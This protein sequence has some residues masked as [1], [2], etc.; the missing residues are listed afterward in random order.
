[1]ALPAASAPAFADEPALPQEAASDVE[2]HALSSE[3]ASGCEGSDA[4]CEAAAGDAVAPHVGVA[5][6]EAD[7]AAMELEEALG[8][9]ESDPYVPLSDDFASA[10]AASLPQALKEVSEIDAQ[11]AALGDAA[12]VAEKIAA[13]TLPEQ[14][15]ILFLQRSL[16]EDAGYGKLAEF[17]GKSQD[18][19]AFLQWLLSDYETLA[20]YVT[21][22]RPGGNY[23]EQN[24]QMAK[25]S[26]E[27][28]IQQFMDI[29]RAN[30][31]DLK[32]SVPEADRLVYK[33]MM[34]SAA[35][36]MHSN[37]RLWVGN[38]NAYADP[39]DRYFII[40]TF[41][42][43]AQ[44]YHFNKELFDRLPVE[45]MRWVFENRISNEEMP[46]LANY[47]ISKYPD[48]EGARMNAYNYVEYNLSFGGYGDK[49]FFD[50]HYLYTEGVSKEP[51]D[52]G[53]P[54]EGGYAKKYRFSYE[55]E[56]FPNADESD[57][58]YYK[59]YSNPRGEE[60]RLWMPFEKGGVCGAL[61]KTY[62]NLSGIAGIPAA[63]AGQPKHA[64]CLTYSLVEDK[65]A[66][67]D[68]TKK[69]FY[70]LVNNA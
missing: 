56:N 30:E 42:A 2:E 18:H 24:T 54:I 20:L 70:S 63:D 64:V 6:G 41:R 40:K 23:S 19:S 48:D 45:N 5:P 1:M 37:T 22:G 35:L 32:A 7:I 43:N 33:K 36:G 28:S 47:T 60:L 53:Q 58:Y 15:E 59:Q 27:R 55:D 38:N 31:A 25:A 26:H 11:I 65:T 17:A 3:G 67:S 51:G 69:P 46:W 62:A 57:P 52:Y 50:E 34:I 10:P 66:H 14:E 9:K 49:E 13:G 29:A 4:Q 68:G 39:V 44:R 8:P 21:G 61:A 12:V 16:I